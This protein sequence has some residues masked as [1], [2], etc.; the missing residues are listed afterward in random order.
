M[1]ARK[2]TNKKGTA[3]A[4]EEPAPPKSKTWKVE[5][6]INRYDRNSGSSFYTNASTVDE[7]ITKTFAQFKKA[8]PKTAVTRLVLDVVDDITFVA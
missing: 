4:K 8:H 1:A 2:S 6:N 5:F 3:P 7:A